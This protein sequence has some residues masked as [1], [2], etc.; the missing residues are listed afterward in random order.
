M[1][2]VI[3]FWTVLMFEQA[4]LQTQD[5]T[6]GQIPEQRAGTIDYSTRVV[7]G[8][9]PYSKCKCIDAK[10]SVKSF[11][12]VVIDA[13]LFLGTDGRFVADRQATIFRVVDGLD[14]ET[15]KVFHSTKPEQCGLSFDYGKEYR[16][17]VRSEKGIYETDYCIDPRS[18]S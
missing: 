15:V 2:L 7:P 17:A 11:D 10:P 16:I 12:G 8:S 3:F 1:S 9:D 5:E 4:S 18:K 14:G 13:A 6:L